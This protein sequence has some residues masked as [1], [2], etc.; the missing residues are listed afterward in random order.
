MPESALDHV[1]SSFAAEGYHNHRASRHSDILSKALLEALRARCEPLARD[2]QTG[3]VK[4]WFNKGS[5]GEGGRTRDLLLGTPDKDGRRP[6]PE[7]LRLCF[8]HKTVVTAHRNAGNRTKELLEALSELHLASP[9]ALKVATLLVGTAPRYLNVPDKVKPMYYRTGRSDYF[10]SQIRPR[11]SSGDAALWTD[12][13][14]AISENRPNGPSQTLKKFR[15]LPVREV[16]QANELGFDGLLAVPVHVDN[17]GAPRIDRDNSL[18]IDI[19]SDYDR[20]LDLVAATYEAR[21]A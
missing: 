1:V 7:G 5:A 10:E 16:S 19:D 3:A 8:E 11:F 20:I 12:F 2:I 18:G 4:A 9:S 13:P 6:A 15:A 14:W 21:W 17:V